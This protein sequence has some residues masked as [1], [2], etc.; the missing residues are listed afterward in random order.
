MVAVDDDDDGLWGKDNGD[1]MK[2][3]ENSGEGLM[4]LGFK[5]SLHNKNEE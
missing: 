5:T 1:E 2:T 3:M 4:A